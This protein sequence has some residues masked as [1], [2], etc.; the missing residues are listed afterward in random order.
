MIN[1]G[2]QIL[3]LRS[4]QSLGGRYAFVAKL[5]HPHLTR[6]MRKMPRLGIFPNLLHFVPQTSHNPNVIPNRTPHQ[7]RTTKKSS[8]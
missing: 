3:L 1:N 2:T 5:P 8:S 7:N 6:I 4:F